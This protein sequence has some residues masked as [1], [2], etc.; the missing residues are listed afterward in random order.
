MTTDATTQAILLTIFL[1]HDQSIALEE[2]DAALAEKG[3]WDGFPPEG[4]ELV[5]WHVAMGLG[6][7]VTLSVPLDQISAV[8]VEIERKAWGVYSTDFYLTY[9]F[10]PARR[11]IAARFAPEAQS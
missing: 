3:W 10:E 9:D 6:H 7:I 5:S 11:R 1:K 8:N 4:C 2:R